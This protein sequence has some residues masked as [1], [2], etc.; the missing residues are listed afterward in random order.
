M[1]NKMIE[2]LNPTVMSYSRWMSLRRN[3]VNQRQL[4]VVKTIVILTI[5]LI[6]FIISCNP[7]PA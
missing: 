1:E 7:M 2:C 6:S 3:A 5:V 4:L